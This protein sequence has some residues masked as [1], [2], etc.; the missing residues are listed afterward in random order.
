MEVPYGE[1][2]GSIFRDRKSIRI[3][4]NLIRY[5]LKD[6]FFFGLLVV[7][8]LYPLCVKQKEEK[9]FISLH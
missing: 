6:N 3:H 8:K 5:I 4:I 1:D 7:F 9:I 2:L